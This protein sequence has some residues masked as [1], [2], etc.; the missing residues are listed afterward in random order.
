MT[1][2]DKISRKKEQNLDRFAK[3]KQVRKEKDLTTLVGKKDF[4]WIEPDSKKKPTECILKTIWRSI[5]RMF[6]IKG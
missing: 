2:E 4:K 1:M 5:K 3:N 6:S